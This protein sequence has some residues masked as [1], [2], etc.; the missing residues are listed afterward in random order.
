MSDC[1]FCKIVNKEIPAKLVFE[2]DFALAFEDINPVA[3]VHIL[4]IP[5][6]HYN[7]IADVSDE[8]LI[9]KLVLLANKIAN[10]HKL[11]NGYR[12]IIN[13]GDDGG[14]TVHHLHIHII[15]G[16]F[17]KWPPG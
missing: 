6:V 7:S 9:G 11:D 13:K 8:V 5:K 1:I 12:M 17:M 4:L 3:K 15:G 14:Q 16:R 2:N 10:D